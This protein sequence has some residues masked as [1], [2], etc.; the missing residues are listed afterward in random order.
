MTRQTLYTGAAA[1]DGTG[2]TLRQA[3]TKIN[4]NFGELYSSLGYDS[5]SLPTNIHFN[6]SAIVFEPLNSNSQPMEL[7]GWRQSGS[8]SVVQIPPAFGFNQEVTLNGNFQ[9]LTN[10]TLT[11]PVLTNP[12]IDDTLY[13]L[14]NQ[15][16]I[17]FQSTNSASTHVVVANHATGTTP[18]FDGPVINVGGTLTNANLKLYGKGNGAVVIDKIA[19]T[20]VSVASSGTAPATSGWIRITASS[21]INVTLVNGTVIGERKVITNEG[22]G[23]P[24]VIPTNFGQY[25]I[26]NSVAFQM[27]NGSATELLWNGSNWVF[28]GDKT[29]LTLLT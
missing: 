24:V 7:R 6:D 22:T 1:N 8:K 18:P 29:N 28:I 12:K 11:T 14:A 4:E 25:N 16:L 15:E 19:H 21:N 10:K 26:D 27:P 3:A 17:E 20:F 5:N 23:T 9:T 2:D 13:D